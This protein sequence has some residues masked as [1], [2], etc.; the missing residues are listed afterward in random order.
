MALIDAIH[1]REI[2]DS[3]GNPTVEVEVL[4][5]DGQ[6]GRAAVPS[7]ASTGE[8][9]AVELRDGDKG[10]YLGKGVQ[11]AVDAVIDEISPALIGFD[12]TDQRSIDQAMIDLDG[13]PNKGKLG[14]NAI[15]GVSL[16][17][18]N[19]AAA[20]ADLPLYKYLGGPNA[21]VLPV[22]LMNIL[23]G[24]SHA[25]SDVDIQE[26]MIAPIGAETFS[27]GLRWGVEVYHNLKAV[28]QEKGLSTGLGDE[29]GFAPNLPSNRAALD[30]IQEAIKNA[31]YTPGTDIALALDVAS[32]EFFKDGAYQFEGKALSATEMSAYYAELVADYP[33]VSIEDPLDE[34]DWEGWKTLTDTIGDK[35]QLVGDDLFVTN[36]VRLQ[37]GIDAATAN[38]L[39]VKVNQIGSLTET[40]DAVS[41][42]QRSGYTTIT[43][44]RSGETED[45][46]I[47]DIA[48]ATNAGQIKTGA[49]ARSERVAKYNQLLRIEEELDDAAR[50]AGRSAFPRF[51]G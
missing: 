10:R 48:V 11:K 24:G 32:S 1:A 39:L 49:P 50:Y 6:I 7:G 9:E 35:V 17:V 12:A 27:E 29:G 28:L 31:G 44:H 45:T 20:S 30:L 47:A 41:L 3:R 19:A 18:A 46:T 43:S 26:F 25:D 14:A 13:T 40:L 36:P 37:Q 15:L 42:A 34:N 5:S 38:S 21:H 33:L 4:L 23:N 16:A 22:P 8:H 51:K 2:L